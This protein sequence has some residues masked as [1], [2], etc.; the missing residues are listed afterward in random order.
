V[1]ERKGETD[2]IKR[3]GRKT[4]AQGQK[5]QQGPR[6]ADGTV[7]E[8]GKRALQRERESGRSARAMR[9]IAPGG[10]GEKK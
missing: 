3:G 2:E 9:A 6:G 5:L 1:R 10:G 7:G 8:R 4:T